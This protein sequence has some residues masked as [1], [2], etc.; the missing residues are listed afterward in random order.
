MTTFHDAAVGA[1][2]TFYND[3]WKLKNGNNTF[4]LPGGGC[5]WMAG[6]AFHTAVE[7]MVNTQQTDF[8]LAQEAVAFFDAHTTPP[9]H[10]PWWA[11]AHNGQPPEFGY[12]VDDYGWWG[13][14]FIYSYLHADALGYNADFKNVLLLYATNCWQA[15]HACWDPTPIPVTTKDGMPANI[16][17]GI[18]NTSGNGLLAGRNCVTNECFWRLSTYLYKA[19]GP[20]GQ[21]YLDPNTNVNNFFAQAKDYGILFYSSNGLVLERF[22]GLPNTDHPT[23]TWLGDQGLFL[24]CCY[25]NLYPNGPTQPWSDPT[26]L[27]NNVI[28]ANT[29]PD[30]TVLHEGLAPWSGSPPGSPDFRLDYACGKGTFMRNL[31]Y[32]TSDYHDKN[33]GNQSPY[34]DFI[35]T[36]AIAVW[37]YLQNGGLCPFYWSN[38][39][40]E[41]ASWGYDQE[42]ANAV[43]Y[44]A[45]LSAINAAQVNWAN[46]NID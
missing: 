33:F 17:G 40:T 31:M 1:L 28:K 39:G 22:F 42:V 15:L 34:D 7:C 27:F 19:Y 20:D 2:K 26:E 29:T 18:P 9:N 14:A 43:L 32:L 24:A 35:R 6:N 25:F 3:R 37:K 10:P 11:K 45:G 12:W 44:A 23:W 21:N 36:N 13:N 30:Q 8:G 16:T 41:P 38:D 5:F 4:S 46:D